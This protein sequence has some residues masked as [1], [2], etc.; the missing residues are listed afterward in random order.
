[1]IKIKGNKVNYFL[2]DRT[3]V[4]KFYSVF[5]NTFTLG[6]IDREIWPIPKAVRRVCC[7]HH[8]S[9]RS[10]LK[11]KLSVKKTRTKSYK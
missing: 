9:T 2:Y 11:I 6:T 8:S 5:I 4:R 7:D 3:G 10:S 1:M